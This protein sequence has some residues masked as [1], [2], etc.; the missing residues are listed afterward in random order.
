M[1]H[2]EHT[3]EGR[4]LHALSDGRFH[5]GTALGAALGLT[6]AGVGRALARLRARGLPVEAVRGRGYRIPGGYE[7]LVAR[8][9]LARWHGA[10]LRPLPAALRVEFFPDSTNDLALQAPERG[11]SVVLAEGQ[12]AGR[13]RLG[14]SWLSPLGGLYCSLAC[15][16]D[17]L[18]EPPVPL[19][20]GAAVALAVALRARGIEVMVKWPN[21][22]L[23]A[24]HKVGGIL[25]ELRGEPQGPCR[26]VVGVGLNLRPPGGAA[27][28]GAEPGTLFAADAAQGMRNQLAGDAVLAVA[29]AAARFQAEGVAP[30]LAGWEAFDALRGQRLWLACGPRTVIGTACGIDASGRLRLH[31]E[32]G[33][34]TFSSGEAQLIPEHG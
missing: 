12:R 18:P 29:S 3:S 26:I 31:T 28:L 21:D 20:L 25:T 2:L 19:A 16:F 23:I 27:H 30:L 14:R 7:P 24:G 10:G 22:L 1:D 17:A 15:D 9:L 33:Y 6:R 5:S 4:L 32:A 11:I 8:E 34:E 13:G